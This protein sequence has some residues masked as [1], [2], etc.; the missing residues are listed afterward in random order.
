MMAGF[1]FASHC[2][3]R[4]TVNSHSYTGIVVT[5]SVTYRSTRRICGLR[6][7]AVGSVRPDANTNQNDDNDPIR[8]RAGP[9]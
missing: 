4:S 7:V 9:G 6:Q 5:L 2:S 1:F 8:R 3:W